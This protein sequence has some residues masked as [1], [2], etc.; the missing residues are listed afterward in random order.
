MI[1]FSESEKIKILWCNARVSALNFYK[2]LGFIE[3]EPNFKK[4]GIDYII[5]ELK[6]MN[7]D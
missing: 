4:D 2:K 7:K 3:T 6:L 5:M 1:H